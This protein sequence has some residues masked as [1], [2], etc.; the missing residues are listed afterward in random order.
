M[1][2]KIVIV[3][4]YNSQFISGINKCMNISLLDG[5][6]KELITDNRP[7]STSY[8][9]N[10]CSRSWDLIHQIV[11]SYYHYSNGFVEWSIPTVKRTLKKV[12]YDQH[13]KYFALLLSNSQS[14]KNRISPAQI[15][16]KWNLRINLFFVKLLL[17]Q[18]SFITETPRPLK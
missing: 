1:N 8:Y 13:D 3:A 11:S 6:P 12:K 4:D 18:Q 5:F 14:N 2:K 9:F 15:S 16:I 17:P 10:K 7:E